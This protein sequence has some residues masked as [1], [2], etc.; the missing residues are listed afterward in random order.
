MGTQPKQGIVDR[1]VELDGDHAGGLVDDE[2]EVR[3]GFELGAQRTGR[4]AGLHLDDHPA[5]DVGERRAS[6]CWS[7]VERSG[8]VAIQV[9]RAETHVADRHREPEHGA[10]PDATA[11]GGTPPSA[12]AGCGEIGFADRRRSRWASMHGPSPNVYCNS[13]I[14]AL[15]PLVVHIEPWATSSVISTIPAPIV[16]VTATQIWHNR[17]MPTVW[18]S[19]VRNESRIQRR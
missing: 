11:A 8:S 10:G 12:N 18:L 6:A 19:V 5:G 1:D 2:A 3:T 15:T 17:S 4:G 7:A 13:S 9:E 16:S 14:R